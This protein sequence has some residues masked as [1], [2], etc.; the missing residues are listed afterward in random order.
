MKPH[1][2]PSA[3]P[4]PRIMACALLMISGSALAAPS[5]LTNTILFIGDSHSVES[6]GIQQDDLLRRIKSFH[7]ASYAVCGSTP[8]TWLQGGPTHC[9]YFFR[10]TQGMEQRGW[11]AETPLL[12]K[13]IE[14]HHPAYT[15]VELGTNLYGHPQAWIEQT[16]HEMAMTI[17]NSGS[18]CIWIGPPSIRNQPEPQ[19]SLVFDALK[20]AVGPYCLLFDSRNHTH[21]PVTGGDGVHFNTLGV[22]GQQMAGNW[23]LAAFYAFSPIIKPL[24]NR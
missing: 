11:D 14:T 23:A 20:T 15:I 24:P 8:Q 16:S 6:F 19:L 13:L 12:A 3:I 2:P 9:G 21:Y 5:D 18:K 17:V 4:H 10:N 1:S 22:P 7:V